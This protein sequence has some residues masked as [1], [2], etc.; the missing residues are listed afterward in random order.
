MRSAI[1]R[2]AGHQLVIEDLP[3]PKPGKSPPMPRATPKRRPPPSPIPPSRRKIRPRNPMLRR[4]NL[5]VA[6]RIE[7]PHARMSL[8]PL[9]TLFA[10]ALLLLAGCGKKTAAEI[11]AEQKAALKEEKRQEAIKLLKQLA[12]DFPDQPK[13]KDAPAE[14]AALEAAAPKK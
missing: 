4:N 8:R 2:G 11:A 5:A 10:A 9:I 1:F 3:I 13:A 14:A 7:K 6:R 12:T